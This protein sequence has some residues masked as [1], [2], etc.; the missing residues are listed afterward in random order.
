MDVNKDTY[1]GPS[2]SMTNRVLRV[3]WKICYLTCFR[4]SPR[5]FHSWRCFLL[6]LFGAS[7]GRDVHI[8]PSVSIWAP[9]NLEIGNRCGVGDRAILYTQDK[10]TMGDEVVISQGVHL[11]AGSH[12]H[13]KEGFPL[14]T[15]PIHLGS[16]IWIAADAFVHP[17]IKIEDGVVV[18]ARSVVVKD[19]EAWKIYSGF[20]AKAIKDRPI[21]S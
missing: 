3:L 10:I 13:E 19:L 1:V 20:P 11:C 21:P 8:Y 16:Q 4:I 18:G 7:I 12:D 17:G 2:F 14:I 6:R 9:W 15:K 5:P